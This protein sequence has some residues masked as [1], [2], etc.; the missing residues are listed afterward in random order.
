[1]NVRNWKFLAMAS[2]VICLLVPTGYS[3]AQ[4]D[5]SVTSIV[6]TQAFQTATNSMALVSD[7]STTVRV[8]VGVDGGGS[9]TGITGVLRV[10]VNGTEITP[11]GGVAPIN[12]G[13]TAPAAASWDRDNEDHTLN[14]ELSAPTGLTPT[15][16]ADFVVELTPLA[17]ETNTANNTGSVDNL[18]V[19]ERLSPKFYYT[20]INYIPAGAGL[21]AL[22]DVQAGV[23]DAFVDG[24]YPINDADPNL[25]R[26][27]LFP[28]LTWNQDPN[29]N[30]QIDSSNNEHSDI[31]DWL[32]SCRQLIVDAE[33][34]GDTIFLYGWVAGN[35][36]PSNGWGRTGGRVAFGNTQQ[37]RHQRT[38]A[39][40]LGHNFGLGHNSN[41]L[42]PDTGWDTGAR[43]DGNPAGNNT[44]G[45]V[46]PSS[47]N[48][49]MVGGQLT[50]S[51][52]VNQT[53]YAS[54]LGNAVL[55][56]DGPA[57][58]DKRYQRRV[59]V[60]SGVLNLTV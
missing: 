19:V 46:K 55:A 24:I 47:L 49:I 25:Y 54:F 36:I 27:G 40:E 31:L 58:S 42:A 53:T 26:E 30:G 29:G 12:P 37:T 8:R 41:T 43:L 39:H 11:A 16:D 4:P 34:N 6:V 5:I 18:T 33:G 9:Q 59:V 21:P 56:P 14:F 28:T 38:Y 23:G 52:W 57:G 10:S 60:V 2:T 51:A 45:R 22:A 50:N 35:P 17:G 15:I 7:R 13:F 32:E 48:D 3:Q 20:R 44:T 1:M